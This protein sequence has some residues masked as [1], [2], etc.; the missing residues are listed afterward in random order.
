MYLARIYHQHLPKMKKSLLLI[1]ALA[2]LLLSSCF[3]ILEEIYLEKN[4]KGQYL[5]TIDMSALMDESMKELLQGAGEEGEENSLEGVEIDSVVYF[6]D[7]DPE[8]LQAMDKPEIFER[9]FMKIQMSD[10]QDKMVMQFG[11]DFENVGE[12]AYFLQNIDKLMGDSMEGNPMGGGLLPSFNEAG[13]FMQKGKKLTRLASLSLGGE[14]ISEDD[15]G[16]LSMF[17][18]SAIF[19][20]VYHLPGKVKKTNIPNAVIDGNTLMIESSMLDLM[21][22]EAEQKGWVK[23]K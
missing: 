7:S 10:E 9:A 17:M 6:K 5:Y 20:T 13:M 14:E 2:P 11:L 23:F 15:M 16:M 21:K 22:G 12:I 1:L 8:M 4:G 18:E 19:R 3:D